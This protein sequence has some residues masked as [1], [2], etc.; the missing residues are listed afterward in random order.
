[1]SASH[2]RF[3][4]DSLTAHHETSL[5]S[6]P[7]R[8]FWADRLQ[9]GCRRSRAPLPP[10]RPNSANNVATSARASCTAC[11]L[12]CEREW[13]R[14]AN[15][16]NKEVVQMRKLAR[17]YPLLIVSTVVVVLA[18]QAQGSPSEVVTCSST[19]PAP[20]GRQLT[21]TWTDRGGRSYAIRQI[22]T[23]LWWAG[24]LGSRVESSFFGTLSSSGS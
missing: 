8:E 13:H 4:R 21:G 16:V 23:C 10:A 7:V 20:G 5:R 2:S 9:R 11:L 1:M 19:A 24:S 6:F 12:Y 17:S 14:P 18:A 3:V 15:A 22:G